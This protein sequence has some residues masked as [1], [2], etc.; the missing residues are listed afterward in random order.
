MQRKRRNPFRIVYLAA[1]FLFIYS[2]CSF[3]A[4]SRTATTRPPSPEATGQSP[5]VANAELV[6]LPVSITDGSGNFVSGLSAQNFRVYEDGRLQ[7]VLSF[8][9]GDN[10]VT[11]GMV[12]DHSRSMGPKLPEVTAAV[13]DFAKSSNP[14]DEMFVV[15]FNDDVSVELLDGKAF[16]N[17][18]HELEKAVSAVSARGRTALYDAVAEGLSA[19]AAGTVGQEGSD[20][21]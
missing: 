3:S 2:F 14:K 13:S 1:F 19:P 11:V 21:R 9:D 5:I 12:V 18:A 4:Y 16:T 17:S 8:Q 15:D 7:K 10:P 20:Y 6:V